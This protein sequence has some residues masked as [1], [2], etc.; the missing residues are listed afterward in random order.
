MRFLLTVLYLLLFISI[1][2]PLVLVFF[3]STT[4]IFYIPVRNILSDIKHSSLSRPSPSELHVVLQ[5][6]SLV[7]EILIQYPYQNRKLE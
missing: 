7:S 3:L 6:L 5:F 2:H 1:E 4:H